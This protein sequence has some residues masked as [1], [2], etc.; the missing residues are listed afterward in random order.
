MKKHAFTTGRLHEEVSQKDHPYGA[1]FLQM[2]VDGMQGLANFGFA[3][4][5]LLDPERP[6]LDFRHL[7][8]YVPLAMG[9]G[10]RFGG[11]GILDV[12]RCALFRLGG[13]HHI[14][15]QENLPKDQEGE[16]QRAL[17]RKP[18]FGTLDR[19]L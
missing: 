3:G 7:V 13:I 5:H 4:Y 16:N 9:F 18:K 2:G 17:G 11:L 14:G 10:C 6:H 1:F 15:H 8:F 12:A 19:G